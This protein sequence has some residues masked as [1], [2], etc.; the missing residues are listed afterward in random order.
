MFSISDFFNDQGTQTDSPEDELEIDEINSDD[1]VPGAL[2]R[3]NCFVGNF[4]KKIKLDREFLKK[5][6]ENHICSSRVGSEILLEYT[7]TGSLTD[8]S[9]KRLI[10]ITAQHLTEINGPHPTRFEKISWA[11]ALANIF[12]NLCGGDCT[13]FVC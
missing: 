11:K 8:I 10:N 6:L 2:R 1:T 5:E 12:P 9:R 7:E 4:P 13:K 3:Q